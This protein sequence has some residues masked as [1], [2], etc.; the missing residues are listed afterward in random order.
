MRTDRNIYRNV[1]HFLTAAALTLA[2]MAAVAS[3][4]LSDLWNDNDAVELHAG[5][6]AVEFDSAGPHHRCRS[7]HRSRRR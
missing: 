1:F 6:M 5:M 4:D 7:V 2:L 3:A